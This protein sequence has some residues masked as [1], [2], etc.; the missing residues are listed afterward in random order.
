VTE[1]VDEDGSLGQEAGAQGV[2]CQPEW[3]RGLAGIPE[4][5]AALRQCN[6]I[7]ERLIPSSGSCEAEGWRVN[8]VRRLRLS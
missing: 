4:L 3:H 5:A 8:K 1:C 2:L 6:E 7:V